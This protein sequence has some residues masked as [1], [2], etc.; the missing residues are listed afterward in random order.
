MIQDAQSIEEAL[1]IYWHLAL[2]D[3]R[4]IELGSFQNSLLLLTGAV[5]RQPDDT[6]FAFSP[7]RFFSQVSLKRL[8]PWACLRTNYIE[9]KSAVLAL[10][11]KKY[12][13]NEHN[14]QTLNR[15]HHPRKLTRAVRSG[16]PRHSVTSIAVD[17]LSRL[18]EDEAERHAAGTAVSAG[19]GGTLSEH[20]KD[21]AKSWAPG[22]SSSEAALDRLH[23]LQE[24]EIEAEVPDGHSGEDVL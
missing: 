18:D 4:L 23:D 9:T 24:L 20:R 19:G 10:L 3:G 12:S 17:R 6:Q 2:H 22:F 1:D 5:Q 16:R 8:L 11:R 14:L 15:R 13:S 7:S 21:R